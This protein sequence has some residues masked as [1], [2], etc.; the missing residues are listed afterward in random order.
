M[1]TNPHQDALDYFLKRLKETYPDLGYK[2]P[3]IWETIWNPE[4]KKPCGPSK[5]LHIVFIP[6]NWE[7]DPNLITLPGYLYEVMIDFLKAN[8]DFDPSYK[9][10][11]IN[12]NMPSKPHQT[13][14]IIIWNKE[15]H[16]P[17]RSPKP[18][19][20]PQLVWD[21][22]QS[23]D[24]EVDSC[25]DGVNSLQLQL[26][27]ISTDETQLPKMIAVLNAHQKSF[28]KGKLLLNKDEDH[29]VDIII[30]PDNEDGYSVIF[31]DFNEEDG[32][33]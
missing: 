25:W 27:H 17:T 32:G 22:W 11:K 24:W 20:C 19:S 21:T 14:G 13:M 10:F 9:E 16:N 6:E 8:P 18:K 1:Q 23:F 3:R 2:E 31:T 33:Q 29:R 7:E 5:N 30:N 4:T 26:G 15:A 28:R 12:L